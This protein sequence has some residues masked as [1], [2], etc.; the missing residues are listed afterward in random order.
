MA[1]L[2]A[3]LVALGAVHVQV[4]DETGAPVAGANVRFISAA[5]VDESA[6][7]DAGGRA[8]AHD[9]FPAVRASIDAAGF[10]PQ[11]VEI[12]ALRGPVVLR[13]RAGVIG[14]VRVA[15]GSEQ[16]LHRL[17]FPASLMDTVA[18]AN[19]P[20]STSDALLRTL[21]GFDRD[22]SNSAF[23]NY[24]QL[25]VSFDGAGNDRGVVFADGVPAQDAFGGQVDWQALPADD[26]TRAELLRGAG[27]A[28]YGSGAVGG[29]LAL[30]TRA[31]A[32]G[33]PAAGWISVGGGGPAASTG[34]LFYRA[35]LGPK[36]DTSLWTSTTEAA[37]DDTP[38]ADRTRV[39][40]IAES[41]SDATALRL[42]AAGGG[43]SWD[44]AGLLASDAQRQ[45]RPNYTF[46]RSLSQQSLRYAYG[47]ARTITDV[48]VYNRD[49]NVTPCDCSVM[50]RDAGNSSLLKAR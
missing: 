33:T 4:V 23:T 41:Q 8:S 31:P 22:R 35:P 3:L 38:P 24:G 25:R 28:L 45:G 15:T 16:S 43:S 6:T 34:E 5:G 1:L 50:K 2:L 39:D 12:A 19:S 13:R 49:T 36:I 42:H 10:V 14:A 30:D 46:A 20:Q 48:L 26:I 7:T 47:G 32:P 27:S 18:V 11:D 21:P 9:G 37:Y 17:S 40:Q 44:F 29:V